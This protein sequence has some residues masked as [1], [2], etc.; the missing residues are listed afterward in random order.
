VKNFE[1]I[2]IVR[3]DSIGD[4]MLTL[5]LA[6]I[7]KK[8]QTC[9]VIF[10][11]K[12]YTAPVIA[13]CEHVD[14]FQDWDSVKEASFEAQVNW[15]QSMKLDA[16]VFAFPD[17]HVMKA[18][19]AAK[20]KIRVATGKRFH[21]VL[22][23]NKR[24]WF[25]RKRSH[26][27][28]AQL[29]T[30]LLAVF[31]ITH[32]P[33]IEELPTL[34]GF[35]QIAELQPQFSKLEGKKRIILHPKSQGSAV[36]WGS[37]NFSML[38]K[39]LEREDVELVI[40]GTQKEFELVRNDLPF[41]QANVRNLMGQMSLEELIAFINSADALVAA[42]TGPLHIAAALGVRA[43]GLYTPKEPMHPG[44]WSPLGVNSIALQADAHPQP[45]EYLNIPIKKV[46]HELNLPRD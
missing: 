38:I 7:I 14:V 13:C 25:S 33:S 15:M 24:T 34:Q 44:R 45:G 32:I 16:I 41:Q 4:V 36:E 3:T 12:A 23:A 19:A 26:L 27:H 37:Q 39:S 30:K 17:K 21:S 40:T 31:G 20:V 42:S 11:G 35:T 1:R 9:E 29:N 8:R 10:I 28:E 22:Y 18:A 5:P 2:A 6:G 43:I 46:L